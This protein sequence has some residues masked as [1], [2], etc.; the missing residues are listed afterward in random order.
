MVRICDLINGN[1]M[2]IHSFGKKGMEKNR[3][4]GSRDGCDLRRRI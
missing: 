2:K 3:N 1:S 4:I